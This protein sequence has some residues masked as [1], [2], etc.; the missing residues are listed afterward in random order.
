MLIDSEHYFSPGILDTCAY[1]ALDDGSWYLN[2][3]V[4]KPNYRGQGLGPKLLDRLKEVFAERVIEHPDW[5][6]CSRLLVE[7]GGYG[8]DV[9]ELH[10]FYKSQGFK[11]YPSPG[12]LVWERINGTD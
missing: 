5:P 6:Q 3:L 1:L 12:C 9:D 8:S 10:K 4:I 2:R 7:P 11:P